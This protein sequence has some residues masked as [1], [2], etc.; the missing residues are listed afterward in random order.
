M[1]LQL[2]AVIWTNLPPKFTDTPGQ[3]LTRDK[4]I[5]YLRLLDSN[6]K[7]LAEEYIRRTPKQINTEFRRRFE[8]EFGWTY[9]G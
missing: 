4:S 9:A 1:N 6:T 7:K 5:E 2:D 3:I 8:A